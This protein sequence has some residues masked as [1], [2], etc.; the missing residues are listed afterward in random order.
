VN[1]AVQDSRDGA[2]IGRLAAKDP[3]IGGFVRVAREVDTRSAE[4]DRRRE[5]HSGA[6]QV[7]ENEFDAA[8]SPRL[9][10]EPEHRNAMVGMQSRVRGEIYMKA[11]QRLVLTTITVAIF[12]GVTHKIDPAIDGEREF[13]N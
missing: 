6:Q 10:L 3:V 5:Q 7:A 2:E 9:R 11:M 12:N 13:V 1:D 8:I 4:N